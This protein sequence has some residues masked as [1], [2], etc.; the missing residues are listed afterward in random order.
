MKMNSPK[1]RGFT[2][3]EILIVMVIFSI[4]VAAIYS[5][6]LVHLKTAMKQDEVVEVQQNLRIAMDSISRD[7]K[8]AGV[9]VPLGTTPLS[10]GAPTGCGA[11]TL[12]I[13]T[14]S[15]DGNMARVT[16]GPFIS[17]STATFAIPVDVADSAYGFKEDNEV[18]IVR[19][20]DN[21]QPLT[22]AGSCL[23]I[24]AQ[25]TGAS[26][27][28]KIESGANFDGVTQINTGDVIIKAAPLVAPATTLPANDTIV[29]TLVTGAAN[30]C[31]VGYCLARQVNPTNPLPAPTAAE[32]VASN[33]TT[34]LTFGYIYDD[35]TEDNNPI[36]VSVGK[37][38]AVRVTINGATTKVNQP[39]S[40]RRVTSVIMLRNR[41]AY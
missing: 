1:Q 8:M 4:V 31:P 19:P 13:N 33:L 18:R 14:M 35:D 41:R 30:N 32:I 6:Y 17:P 26:L 38:K 16:S 23:A 28:L 7:L 29:Y 24:N 5:L 40:T 10:I 20:F 3:V 27:T 37:I 9:L 39:I 34:P 15:P 36:A 22:T 25:P 21:S 11:N 2:L 12:Q